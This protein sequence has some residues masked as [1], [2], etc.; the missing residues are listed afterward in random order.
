MFYISV[1]TTISLKNSVLVTSMKND[2][3]VKNIVPVSLFFTEF[4]AEVA[5]GS[6]PVFCE[7]EGDETNPNREW[8]PFD[9]KFKNF[10]HLNYF[11]GSLLV[12]S[13]LL[14]SSFRL[15]LLL[16]QVILHAFWVNLKWIQSSLIGQCLCAPSA[17]LLSSFSLSFCFGLTLRDVLNLND[18][19]PNI[20]LAPHISY[21]KIATVYVWWFGL[22]AP[23]YFV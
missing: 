3:R 4:S 19:K 1:I 22:R 14:M 20:D 17:W 11:S 18:H 10:A 15:V 9:C 23:S 2:F 21:G 7:N 6:L 12:L 5:P 13:F 16:K 8:F